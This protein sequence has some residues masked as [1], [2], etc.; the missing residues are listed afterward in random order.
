MEPE[1]GVDVYIQA[2]ASGLNKDN[3]ESKKLIIFEEISG[4]NAGVNS[5]MD[6]V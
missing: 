3:V 2:C 5:A 1:S 6:F 4:M